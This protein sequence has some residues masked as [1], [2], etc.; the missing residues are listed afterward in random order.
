[1]SS[2]VFTRLKD[3]FSQFGARLRTRLIAVPS[4]A[5]ET[6]IAKDVCKPYNAIPDVSRS[7]KLSRLNKALEYLYD[8]S[9]WRGS[10][11]FRGC[12]EE[13]SETKISIAIGCALKTCVGMVQAN[14]SM[15]ETIDVKRQEISFLWDYHFHSAV[16]PIL[17]PCLGDGR[18]S[19][20]DNAVYRAV[21]NLVG[22]MGGA[23]IN[24]KSMYKERPT[25]TT[26]LVLSPN[27]EKSVDQ[28]EGLKNFFITPVRIAR[29]NDNYHLFSNS[30]RP[31]YASEF[32]NSEFIKF[33]AEN[34]ELGSL[35]GE[36]AKRLNEFISLG[37]NG[38]QKKHDFLPKQ[39]WD[40]VQYVHSGKAPKHPFPNIQITDQGTIEQM[41]R[42][43]DKLS[44]FHP[45]YMYA[46][47]QPYHAVFYLG[48]GLVLSMID[49]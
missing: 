5:R 43:L 23:Y 31:H 17:S 35:D 44:F 21:S 37:L 18:K 8:V 42:K 12:T 38:M 41:A 49:A 6:Q 20:I 46:N 14:R 30:R 1:G 15:E 40:F 16:I 28:F 34:I 19:N 3:R 26:E 9:W 39:C 48:A 29:T 10:S 13:D 11:P 36:R 47:G 22:D 33:S 2:R 45:L 4:S 24:G 27:N 25:D 32:E 7:E